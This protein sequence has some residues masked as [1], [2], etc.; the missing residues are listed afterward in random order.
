MSQTGKRVVNLEQKEGQGDWNLEN[1]KRVVSDEA[2][3]DKRASHTLIIN[4]R[5][6]SDPLE[7]IQSNLLLFIYFKG[8][9]NNPQDKTEKRKSGH[10]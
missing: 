1:E 8:A 4:D 5:S 10:D 7:H 3:G 9:V 6:G 2:R